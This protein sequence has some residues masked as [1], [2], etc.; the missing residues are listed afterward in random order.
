MSDRPAPGTVSTGSG[1]G[2]E[3][4]RDGIAAA[5]SATVF[6]RWIVDIELTNRCN[7]LCNFCPRDKTPR[8]GFMSEAILR[9]AVDRVA[10]LSPRCPVV[11][12][13]QGEPLLHPMV[14]PFVRQVRAQGLD[15]GLTTNGA[16][17]DAELAGEL[18][19]AG[20]DRIYFSVSDL[21]ADYSRVYHL[22][23]SK[24]LKNILAFLEMNSGRCEVL[25]NIVVRPDNAAK[26]AGMRAFWERL[27]ITRFNSWAVNNRGGSCVSDH[28]FLGTDRLVTQAREA[29]R[30][31]GA[32]DVCAVPYK[33]VFVGWNGNYYICCN[34]YAKARPLGTVEELGIEELDGVKYAAY[35]EGL[36]P[37]R[38][39]N[40]E[41][42]NAV[43]EALLR[44]EEGSAPGHGV[45]KVLAHL[46]ATRQL[47][48]EW[49]CADAGPGGSE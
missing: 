3:H 40:L 47:L 2:G 5:G 33:M 26:V 30:A 35:R 43:R 8:Q 29:I 28:R 13:G 11:F 45:E 25:V 6:D 49:L 17:L 1:V 24:T 32:T 39:C 36:E 38:K 15:C 46:R 10:E 9:R 44:V 18:L 22:E 34:D 48:P 12:T 19:A 23:F 21:Y 31:C 42:V 27:G 41:P 4:S 20:L 16:L 37:C 7:A 14:V